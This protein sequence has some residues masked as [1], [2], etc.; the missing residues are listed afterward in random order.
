MKNKR[1]VFIGLDGVPYTLLK[2]LCN[3]GITPNIKKLIKNGVFKKITSTLPEVSSVAWPSIIT[4]KNP[5]GHGI[6]GFTDLEKNSYQIRFPNFSDLKSPAFWKKNPK[7]RYVIINVPS[8]YPA[9]ALNGVLISGF[10]SPLLEK[11]VYPKNLLKFLKKIN[12]RTDVNAELAHQDMPAFIEDLFITLESQVKLYRYLWDSQK[13]DVFMFV[14]TGTDR[15]MH[16]LW[17]ACEDKNHRYHQAFLKYFRRID[18]IIAEISQQ[19][20]ETD[21]LLLFSDHGFEGLKKDI[22]INNILE[23]EG[24]L[25]LEG[26]RSLENIQAGTK[27]FCL[28]PA[29]IYLN[30]KGRFPKGEVKLQEK[31]KLIK[32]LTNIFSDFKI[33]G[34]KTIKRVY[35]KEEIYSGPLLSSAP[36]LVLLGNNGFNLKAGLSS[37]D[38]A[39]KGIFSGKHTYEN[40]FLIAP[41]EILPKNEK[42]GSVVDVGRLIEK[43]FSIKTKIN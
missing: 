33:N 13:W 30:L 26:K 8:T 19:L 15:L 20:K 16:F 25:R 41:K 37:K 36:D 22:Y 21:N 24:F 32:K 3:K 11:S 23:Q 4:A 31:E 38:T 17:D 10:V 27:A 14:F 42:C 2:G 6:F 29:R 1:S 9:Q 28:D 34:E 18:E 43:I 40:A 7:L 39:S 5:A 35:R 12:Y